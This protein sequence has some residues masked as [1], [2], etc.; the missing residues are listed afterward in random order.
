MINTLLHFADEA[1]AVATLPELRI[2]P[3][4]ADIPS[5]PQPARWV[6][7]ALPVALVTA[8]AVYGPMDANMRRELIAPRET[9][10]GFWLLVSGG[11]YPAEV[12]SIEPETGR[13]L[14][15][16]DGVL[17]ARIDPVFAGMAAVPLW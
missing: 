9:L 13:F 3:V 4:S 15:G 8:E 2:T 17:G 6:E 1:E 14:S 5:T 10:P 7:A 16:D 12:A 11:D